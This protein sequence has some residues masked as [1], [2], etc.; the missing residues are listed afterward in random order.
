MLLLVIPLK[1]GLSR[2]MR[3]LTRTARNGTE[4][5]PQRRLR[6]ALLRKRNLITNYNP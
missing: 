1:M 4:L 3:A 5:A 6:P 2:R